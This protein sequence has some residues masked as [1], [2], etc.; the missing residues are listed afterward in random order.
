MST[1]GPQQVQL[2]VTHDFLV[3]IGPL[4]IG[5]CIVA[6]LIAAVVYGRRRTAREPAPP[7]GPQPRSGAWQTRQEHEDGPPAGSGHG[8]GHQDGGDREGYES[9]RPYPAE[10]P[11]DGI[12]R[13]PYEISDTSSSSTPPAGGQEHPER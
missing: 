4:V 1:H 12:R 8:P 2:A 5:V 7:R 11:R 3:G 6:L 10:V 9:G 13:K